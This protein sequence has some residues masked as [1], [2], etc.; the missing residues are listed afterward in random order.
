MPG[1][2]PS[3]LEHM[4][5][6]QTHALFRHGTR[7]TVP[8]SETLA[9]V[10]PYAARM[11]ITRIGNI[12]GLDN[13]GI[14]VASAM[15]PN[16]RSVSVSLGKGLTL[17]QA[18]AS[19]LM[20]AAENFHGE[21]IAERFHFAS[22]RALQAV[23]KVADPARLCR[24]GRAL[25][26]DTVIPWIEGYDLLR[27][28]PCFVPADLVHT[29]CTVTNGP[30]HS[31]F[32]VSSNGLA[33]GNHLAEAVVAAICEVIERDAVVRWKRCGLRAR[34]QHLLDW[35]TVR[36]P[37]CIALLE[38]YSR[39]G[40]AVRLWDLTTDVGVAT[41]ACDIRPRPDNDSPLR[42]RF[43]AAA[44]HPER[45]LALVGALVEA[46]QTRLNY[47]AGTRDDLPP[48]DYGEPESAGVAEALLDAFAAERA[49]HDFADVPDHCAD[50][51]SGMI[52]WLLD[53]LGHA[54]CERVVAV[55]LTRAEV[56]ISVVRVVIPGLEF[57]SIPGAVA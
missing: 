53:R 52:D 3:T 25:D 31:H 17:D 21:E 33:S 40:L 12:T 16:S 18:M 23:A 55:D 14:P 49:Q 10:L 50:N 11:G 38:F 51:L 6:G 30:D 20:E 57:P 24:T 27:R 35:G 43:R 2:S 1:Q 47:I 7:R 4:L 48:G 44:C 28:E 22:R 8:P 9:R 29:D 5:G 19:A 34:A 54:G 41:F 56:G 45:T 36:D 26:D 15:R 32:A 46:A 39:A 37:D 13:V 42:R